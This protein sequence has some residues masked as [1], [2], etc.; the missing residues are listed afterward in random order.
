MFKGHKILAI[1]PARSGSKGVLNKN[2]KKING[3]PL[4]GYTGEFINS[5]KFIDKSIISTDSS[6][7]QQIAKK[8]F[9][10]SFFK[11]SIKLS[12]SKISDIDV[13]KDSLIKCEEFF[14]TKFDIIAYLQ[15]TSPIRRKVDFINA[16][17]DLINK[18]LDSIWSVS[19]VN[20]KF[21]PLKQ[22]DFNN[23]LKYFDQR[24]E[25]IIARQQLN[26]TY[27]RN[28]VF[29]IFTRECILSQK[30]ILGRKSDFFLI[31]HKHFNIDDKQDINLFRKFL[32][33]DTK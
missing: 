29:Y 31:K 30:K 33:E 12:G 23:N 5:L 27:I 28:G 14:N 24:G 22:L 2:I 16:L 20:I 13:V 8:Y 17:S 11:R 15:P 18:K 26:K 3:K 10:D 21:H 1:V 6:Y 9:L 25:S 19:E 7:Y 4:I 32:N